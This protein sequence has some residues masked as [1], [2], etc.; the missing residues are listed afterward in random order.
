L[1]DTHEVLELRE[2]LFDGVKIGAVGREEE[3]PCTGF[4]DGGSDGSGLVAA[5]I[6]HDH[7]V[8]GPEAGNEHLFDIEQEALAIDGTVEYTGRRNLVAA[9]GGKERHGFPMTMG[10]AAE[11][12]LAFQGPAAQWRH[13]GLGPGF[14]D[15]HQPRGFNPGLVFLPPVSFSRDVRPLLL[16]GVNCFF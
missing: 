12:P 2:D 6:V 14:V 7:D 16:G 10:N 5:Q 9:Q 15:E 1:G 8:A 4:T 13:V 3:E 11:E